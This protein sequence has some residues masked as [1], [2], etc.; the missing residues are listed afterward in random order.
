MRIWAQRHPA[1]GGGGFPGYG[2][3]RHLGPES[4]RNGPE[5]IFGVPRENIICETVSFSDAIRYNKAKQ[6][7][8]AEE[9]KSWMFW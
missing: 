3:D 9:E 6:T 2:G 1:D 7:D 4:V 8:G 5:G